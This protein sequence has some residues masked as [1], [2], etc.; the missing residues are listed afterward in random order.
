MDFFENVFFQTNFPALVFVEIN[1][2]SKSLQRVFADTEDLL[3]IKTEKNSLAE[4]VVVNLRSYDKTSFDT[5][6]RIA[7]P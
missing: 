2:H 3:A 6:L 4:Q 1:V 7:S 5:F